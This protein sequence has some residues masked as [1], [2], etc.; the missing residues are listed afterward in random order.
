MPTR[1]NLE[2]CVRVKCKEEP[3]QDGRMY[4]F[5]VKV[6]GEQEPFNFEVSVS[7][8]AMAT[9]VEGLEEFLRE[10]GWKEIAKRKI[11]QAVRNGHLDGLRPKSRVPLAVESCDLDALVLPDAL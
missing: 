9:E 1:R 5:R 11:T 7:G 6:N 4:C 3:L 10:S 8:T 2:E